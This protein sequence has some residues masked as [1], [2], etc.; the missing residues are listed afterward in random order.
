MIWIFWQ[1]H[2][3]YVADRPAMGMNYS[4]SDKFDILEYDWLLNVFC[5]RFIELIGA[6]YKLYTLIVHCTLSTAIFR[7]YNRWYSFRLLSRFIHRAFPQARQQQ[8]HTNNADIKTAIAEANS[9]EIRNNVIC[10]GIQIQVIAHSNIWM[11]NFRSI[12]FKVRVRAL[13]ADPL[14]S[15]SSGSLIKLTTTEWGSIN[16]RRPAV[17][18]EAATLTG[19]NKW[20]PGSWVSSWDIISFQQKQSE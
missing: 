18:L 6:K 20:T 2:I 5:L 11:M 13:M 16:C 12:D 3:T 1:Q 9:A 4:Y 8:Q 7:F 15:I 17:A 14:L 10:I 19:E